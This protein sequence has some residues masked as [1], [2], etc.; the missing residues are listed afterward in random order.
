MIMGTIPAPL[1]L[2]TIGPKRGYGG[3]VIKFYGATFSLTVDYYAKFGELKPTHLFYQNAGLLEGDVPERDKL[4]PVLVSIV[5]KE[6]NSLC[7]DMH[8]FVYIAR[9]CRN[10]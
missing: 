8:Q 7:H 10:A 6:G 3:Q 9:D 4:G 5:T 2:N 1:I